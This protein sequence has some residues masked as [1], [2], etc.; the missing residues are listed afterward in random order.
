MVTTRR[1]ILTGAIGLGAFAGVASALPQGKSASPPADAY[2]K[3]GVYSSISSENMAEYGAEVMALK[4]R[5]ISSVY[6]DEDR[7]A[8]VSAAAMISSSSDVEIVTGWCAP[9]RSPV[10]LETAVRWL[11]AFSGGRFTLG[12]GINAPVVATFL[13]IKWSERHEYLADYLTAMRRLLDA[14]ANVP[15]QHDGPYL[16]FSRP[17]IPGHEVQRPAVAMLLKVTDLD[18]FRMVG[19]T[20]D[21]AVLGQMTP[22]DAYTAAG[23]ELMRL[24]AAGAGRA[25]QSLR[26]N[27]MVWTLVSDDSVTA[28]ARLRGLIASKIVDKNFDNRSL[29]V[30]AGFADEVNEVTARFAA[31]DKAGAA[32]AVSERMWRAY[33][34][35]GSASEVREQAALY[36]GKVDSLVCMGSMFGLPDLQAYMREH[37]RATDAVAPQ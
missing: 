16:K 27:K 5:G 19:A 10:L 24:G 33:G 13:G 9:G 7:D 14:P 22:L 29:A 31:G 17:G 11:N 25:T 2:P 8:I 12:I 1:E 18:Q 32:Q 36:A 21:G 15:L 6:V 37:L 28:I 4:R 3:I 30:Q 23:R 34:L 26:I 35:A 20:C